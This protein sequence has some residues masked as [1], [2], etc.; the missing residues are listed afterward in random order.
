MEK[1]PS[2]LNASL[3]ECMNVIKNVMFPQNLSM[4]FSFLPS[5]L[6]VLLTSFMYRAGKYLTTGHKPLD[7]AWRPFSKRE[8][9]RGWAPFPCMFWYAESYCAECGLQFSFL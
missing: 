3:N 7:V 9:G 6:I 2:S 5:L 8:A 4:T 1:T